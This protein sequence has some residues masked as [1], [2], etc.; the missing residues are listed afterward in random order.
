MFLYNGRVLSMETDSIEQGFVEFVGKKIGRVGDMS[1]FPGAPEEEMVDVHGGWILP[2][3]VDA[4]T[5]LGLFE[6]SL[7]FEGEDGNEDTDPVTPQLS[8]IDGI[9]PL[10]RSFTEALCAGV[11]C[12]LVSPGSCNPI[13]GQI[14]AIKTCGRCIDSMIVRA[15]CAIKFALGE[16]PKASYNEKDT[17]PVT[18]MATAAL[19][20]D[21]LARAKEY[22][23][24]KKAAEDPTDLPDYDCKL[25]ALLPLLERS[26]QAH[27][28]A[29]RA[30]DI[31][32]ALR[33]SNEFHLDTVIIHGT[34]AH[35][36]ADLLAEVP[37][38]R[39]CSGPCLTDR[40]KPELSNLTEMAPKLLTDA[41]IPTAIITDHPE[42]PLKHYMNCGLAAVRAGM[43]PM[44][45]LRAMTI[46]P[47]EIVGIADRVGSIR[48]GKDADLVV[49][50]GDPFDYR[51]RVTAVIA[52]GNWIVGGK[53][54]AHN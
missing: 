24:R 18:R 22:L 33:I 15:P 21:T 14:A 4:H 34:E 30:D 16:N 47:S 37:D 35:L 43:E 52:E 20:R 28:H 8:V 5:H 48:P 41:G 9:N 3:L 45:A 32:T 17:A 53:D 26:C 36:V 7:G 38:F 6:D 1:E 25:E 13:G 10:E 50:S 12:C 46:V 39:V 27:F 51:S 31:F 11:T 19:I 42:I 23:R 49:F 2:G 29:H 54:Y 40:S 44:Q